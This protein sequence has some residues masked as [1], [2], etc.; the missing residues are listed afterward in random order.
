MSEVTAQSMLPDLTDFKFVTAEF[1]NE[2]DCEK[3]QKSEV[4]GNKV[5]KHLP[6][7]RVIWT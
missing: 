3:W 1:K 6:R 5:V 4:V 7:I 2:M